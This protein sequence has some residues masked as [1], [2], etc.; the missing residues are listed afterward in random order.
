M[1]EDGAE[2]SEGNRRQLPFK[3]CA[4]NERRKQKEERGKHFYWLV[5]Q[6]NDGKEKLSIQRK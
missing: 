2:G 4:E 1:S 3:V 5:M 6:Q